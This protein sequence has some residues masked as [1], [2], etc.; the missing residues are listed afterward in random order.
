MN[1]GDFI[2][3]WIKQERHAK[4]FERASTEELAKAF[5]DWDGYSELLVQ[6]EW[7]DEHE[8]YHELRRRGV[9]CTI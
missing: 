8:L 1:L 7:V 4:I 6:G 5:D 3:T 2:K 9:E